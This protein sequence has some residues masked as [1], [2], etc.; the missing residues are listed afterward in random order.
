MFGFFFTI[1]F[2]AIACAVSGYALLGHKIPAIEF[3]Y[4]LIKGNFVLSMDLLSAYFTF[5]I[6]F[7]GVLFAIYGRSYF[8]INKETRYSWMPYGI[9]FAS[10]LL[11]VNACDI[12]S[13]L[14][15]W[16]LMALSSFFLVMHDREKKEVRRSAWIYLGFTQ[17]STAFLLPFFLILAD[18]AGGIGFAGFQ[19]ISNPGLRHI[20]FV[21]GLLGFG[22]KAGIVP[23]HIW[24]PEAHPAAPS[25][26]SAL[27]SGLMIKTGIYGIIRTFIF[28]GAPDI[29][30]PYT[31]IIVGAISGILGVLLALSEHDIKRLLAYHSVENIGI[32][33]I[34]LG[35]GFLGICINSPVLVILG[36]CGG[37]LH[38]LNHALFKGLLFLSAGSVISRVK[39]RQIDSMGGIMKKMPLTG[40][41]FLI[42][43]LSICGIP[44]FNGFV[45]EFFIYIG[46]FLNLSSG[47]TS[48]RFLLITAVLSLALIGGLALLCFTKAFGIIFLGEP[49]KIDLSDIKEAP[50]P[51]TVPM[52]FISLICLAIGVLPPLILPTLMKITVQIISFYPAVSI[53]RLPEISLYGSFILYV[54]FP[55]LV[56][57]IV[58]LLVR[59]LLS[60]GKKVAFAV[61]WDCGFAKPTARLQYTASSFADSILNFFS[62]ALDVNKHGPHINGYFP[63]SGEMK[64]H[65]NDLSNLLLYNPGYTNI[66]K[67][68]QTFITVSGTRSFHLKFPR[69]I[70]RKKLQ[71]F[72]KASSLLPNLA[73][74]SWN[75]LRKHLFKICLIQNGEVRIYIAYMVLGLAALLFLL[76]FT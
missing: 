49:R 22:A 69:E 31:L 68:F 58:I 7:L 37:L 24:L 25:H 11:V 59:W 19:S 28:L 15:S 34:G 21:L 4:A 47:P 75:A 13:F 35:V 66:K 27:M 44:P 10:M 73:P 72:N 20:L 54:T 48:T 40:M 65:T 50:L 67:L 71:Q 53:S 45:S 32:I 2:G 62:F 12:I 70:F 74:A 63:Q 76:R 30:W 18:K 42:G 57:F 1:I 33:L 46:S 17:I 26:V 52:I 60:R 8:K 29:A 16:E 14:I 61:T 41:V 38:V 9:L 5:F 43:A 36:L 64:I 51:M 56:I 23:V 6:S 55:L 3:P 39:T